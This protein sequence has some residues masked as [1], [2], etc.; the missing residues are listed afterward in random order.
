MDR[1]SQ[2]EEEREKRHERAAGIEK[3]P[4]LVHCADLLS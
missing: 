1:K 3:Q 4:E 2:N